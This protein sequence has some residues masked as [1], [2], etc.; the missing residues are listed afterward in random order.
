MCRGV[1]PCAPV[2]QYAY[3]SFGEMLGWLIGWN[4]TLE[5]AIGAAAVARSWS[6]YFTTLLK[7]FN[8]NSDPM[9]KWVTELDM[10]AVTACPL[11]ALII[12]I[13]TAIMMFGAKESARFNSVVTGVMGMTMR[14]LWLLLLS[15][16]LLLLLVML[17]LILS[18]MLVLT[19][20]DR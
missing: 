2:E 1:C 15:L 20:L 19:L 5:Y 11:A 8:N 7:H 13:C 17:S 16:L 10:G 4:L 18:L 9:P 3:T 6:N 12:L 14:C